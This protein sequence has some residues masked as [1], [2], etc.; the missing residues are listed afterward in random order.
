MAIGGALCEKS[1]SGYLVMF[2]ERRVVGLGFCIKSHQ[3]EK[4]EERREN[5]KR[6][7]AR[8]SKYLKPKHH[9]RD[10]GFEVNDYK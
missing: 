6:V 10:N 2:A 7:L 5:D 4:R 1:Y 9:V 3:R 8:L